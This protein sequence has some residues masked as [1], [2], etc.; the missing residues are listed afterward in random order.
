MDLGGPYDD[1][2]GNFSIPQFNFYGTDYTSVWISSNG[3]LSFDIADPGTSQPSNNALLGTGIPHAAV[4]PFWDDHVIDE[5][6]WTGAGLWMEIA[7]TAPN[8]VITVEWKNTIHYDSTTWNDHRA[9]FQVKLYETTGV[10]ELI[11]DRSSWM[12]TFDWSG[13]VGIEDDTSSMYLTEGSSLN[14][15][16]SNDIRYSPY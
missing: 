4:Y 7:G 6:Y 12:G 8:R 13:T 2:W 15:A 16:P 14:T 9:S 10:I 1:A 11:Y 3:W 5:W